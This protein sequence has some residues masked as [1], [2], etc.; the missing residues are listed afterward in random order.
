MSHPQLCSD[1]AISCLR[2]AG[3]GKNNSAW[4]GP[5]LKQPYK[6]IGAERVVAESQTKVALTEKCAVKRFLSPILCKR[7]QG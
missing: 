1:A 7:K 3:K 6:S 5:V 2:L 4:E